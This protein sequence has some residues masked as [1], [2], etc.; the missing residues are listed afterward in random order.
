MAHGSFHP[1]YIICMGSRGK[2]FQSNEALR[3]K[4]T[5]TQSDGFTRNQGVHKWGKKRDE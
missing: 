3:I 5:G 1:Y 4:S 2:V